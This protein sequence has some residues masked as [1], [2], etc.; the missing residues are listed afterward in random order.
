VYVGSGNCV[1]TQFSYSYLVSPPKCD[2]MSLVTPSD[3][4]YLISGELSSVHSAVKSA[5]EIACL[6]KFGKWPT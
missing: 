6:L 3:S 2:Q 5:A 4:Y 1:N